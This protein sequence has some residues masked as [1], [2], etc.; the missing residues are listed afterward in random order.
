MM[1]G[2]VRVGPVL[3]G[4][5]FL[6]TIIENRWER[7]ES[8]DSYMIGNDRA[9]INLIPLVSGDFWCTVVLNT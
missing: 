3:E 8:A 6:M 9:V 2:F 1:A 7:S 5:T 4:D